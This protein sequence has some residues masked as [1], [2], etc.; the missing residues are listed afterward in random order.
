MSRQFKSPA[1]PFASGGAGEQFE[2]QVQ[3]SY[4]ALMLTRGF[5]PCLPCWP[6]IEVKLQGKIEGYETDDMI[7]TVE[8]EIS[9]ERRKLLGQIKRSVR[10]TKSSSVFGEVIQAAWDDFNNPNLFDKNKDVIGLI[11]GPLTKTDTEVVQL[12]NQPEHVL[13]TLF[14]SFEMLRR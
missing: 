7:I 1:S 14:D 10:I 11:T 3:A 12:F 4:V 13:V 9:S 5:A 8:S 6:I 2:S